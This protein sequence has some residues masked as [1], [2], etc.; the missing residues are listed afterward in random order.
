MLIAV[1]GA[2]LWRRGIPLEREQVFAWLAGALVLIVL[3]RG[4]TPRAAA[5][6]IRDWGIFALLFVAYDYTRGAADTLGM[7]IQ[8]ELPIAIDRWFFPGD[9]PTVELQRALGPLN[10]RQWFEPLVS[11]VYL[12]HFVVPYLFAAVLWLGP[13]ARWR[14][15]VARFATLTAAALVTYVLLPTT[16][17]WLASRQGDIAEIRRST[18]FGWSRLGLPTAERLLA[19]GQASVNLIAALPSLH[20][21]YPMLLL[22]FLWGRSRWPLR[23]ALVTFTVF[24]GFA[25]IISGEHYAF[26]VLL[27][28]AYACGAMAIWNRL[29]RWPAIRRWLDS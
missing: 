8:T 4:G 9:V 12:T 11:I 29:G 2:L 3:A 15:W 27:G 7:P 25:L 17:P 13:R 22:L 19:K 23:V 26:D 5:T 10:G 20:A 16:P 21:A 14:A 1:F 6:A 24:M 28:W 18:G